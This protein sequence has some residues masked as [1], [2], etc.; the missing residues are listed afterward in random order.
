MVT[1]RPDDS[2]AASRARRPFPALRDLL[3]PPHSTADAAP[4]VGD[5]LSHSCLARRRHRIRPPLRGKEGI[6]QRDGPE[7]LELRILIDC[8][9]DEKDDWHVRRLASRQMLICKAEA[10]ELVE[11]ARRL[12]RRD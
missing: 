6:G 5:R 2:R 8:R 1:D 11:V 7:R 3:S 12:W 4:Q 10:L 9:I